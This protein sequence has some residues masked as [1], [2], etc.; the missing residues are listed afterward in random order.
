MT[1]R[2]VRYQ[3]DDAIEEGFGSREIVDDFSIF[4]HFKDNCSITYEQAISKL[5]YLK[6]C[7][8]TVDKYED[9][10]IDDYRHMAESEM[11]EIIDILLALDF[12]EEESK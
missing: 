6:A 9:D 2:D 11:R 12:G 8:E 1:L 7:A 3:I 10:V 4:D 5:E